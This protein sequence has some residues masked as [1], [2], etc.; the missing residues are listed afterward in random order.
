MSILLLKLDDLIVKMDLYKLNI[1]L[2]SVF[3]F[4]SLFIVAASS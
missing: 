2:I 1:I 3:C 4:L